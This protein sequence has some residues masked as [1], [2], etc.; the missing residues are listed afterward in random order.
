MEKLGELLPKTARRLGLDESMEL[1]T[2]MTA[3]QRIVDERVPAASGACR[4]LSLGQGLVIVEAD[5]PIVAQE[6]RLRSPELLAALRSAVQIPIRQLR[7][8]VRHV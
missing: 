6:I 1:A 2:A 8:T 4:L 3:W 7:V 5:A